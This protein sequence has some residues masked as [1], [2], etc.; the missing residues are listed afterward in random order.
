MQLLLQSLTLALLNGAIYALMAMGITFI[1][2]IMRIINWSTGEFYMVGSFA[3]LALLTVIFPALG[4]TL[5]MAWLLSAL[6]AMGLVFVLG[7]VV[8]R[9][10]IAPMHRPG[11][12]AFEYATIMTVALS[13]LLQNGAIMIAGPNQ[14][15]VPDYM[16][17]ILLEDLEIVLNGS[18]V[19]SGLAALAI[20]LLF[21]VLLY[22]TS[23]GL[24]F[25][26]IAQNRLAAETAGL[27]LKTMD[28]LAFGIGTGLCAVA[29]ALLA[30]VFLVHP[31]N[32]A[33]A[34]MKGF[35]IIVI[36]GIGSLGGA[37]VA[38]FGLALVEGLGATFYRAELQ[39]LYGFVFLIGFLVF[40]PQGL[41]GHRERRV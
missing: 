19:A 17:P 28:M 15:S 4:L 32:G 2:S 11:T 27:N 34:T 5:P 21:Y 9:T 40:R 13:V 14:Y 12:Q 37:V 25:R 41:F 6:L 3:H 39:Q 33:A 26:G 16:R 24:A 31:L 38:A 8:Q 23:L 29:G 30:P 36:G 22:R 1:A 35:E 20:I 10:L 18:R 7:M